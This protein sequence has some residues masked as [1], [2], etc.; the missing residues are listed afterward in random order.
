MSSSFFVIISLVIFIIFEL[1]SLLKLF[2]PKLSIL[3]WT[4]WLF[5]LIFSSL[6]Y[7]V[8]IQD[9]FTKI[10]V[11]LIIPA[12]VLGLSFKKHPWKK[13]FKLMLW[14]YIWA[15]PMRKIQ[16]NLL[17]LLLKMHLMRE[18]SSSYF[19]LMTKP[20]I[21]EMLFS[22]LLHG[23]AHCFQAYLC[24]WASY[25][26]AFF[27]CQL[28]SRKSP[29]ICR[30][31]TFRKIYPLYLKGSSPHC[32]WC[33]WLWLSFSISDGWEPLSPYNLMKAIF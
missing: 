30:L 9:P 11:N 16:A 10:N 8:I 19:E 13:K 7:S 27:M 15:Y 6:Y 32:W 31:V 1:I 21:L 18:I 33:S 5:R 22:G 14:T 26:Q 28:N 24:G 17:G 25:L 2:F 23:W 20:I 12:H 3:I 4:P 29:P